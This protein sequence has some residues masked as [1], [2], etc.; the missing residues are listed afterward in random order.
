[1]CRNEYTKAD[2]WISILDW[3]SQT[4]DSNQ[5]CNTEKDIENIRSTLLYSDNKSQDVCLCAF[6]SVRNIDLEELD[7]CVIIEIN[8]LFSLYL[9]MDS[10]CL[11]LRETRQ[12]STTTVLNNIYYSCVDAAGTGDSMYVDRTKGYRTVSMFRKTS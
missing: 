6:G 2:R 1:M 3:E 4:S 8:D 11:F 10:C 9:P 5:C 12:E 7:V